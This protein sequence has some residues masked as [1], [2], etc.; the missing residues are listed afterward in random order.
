MLLGAL[1]RLK[2]SKERGCS[3]K[4]RERWTKREREREGER[5]E[6]GRSGRG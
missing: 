1:D 2:C 6:E 4:E 5:R 3:E